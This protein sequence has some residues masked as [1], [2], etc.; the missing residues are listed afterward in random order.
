MMDNI[1]EL[2]DG[3]KGKNDKYAYQCLKQL[4]SESMKSDAVYAYFD[5]FAAMLDNA[6]SYVRTRGILLI[7]SNAD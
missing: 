5:I 1:Q 3:L 7:A 6:N 4:E 2:I